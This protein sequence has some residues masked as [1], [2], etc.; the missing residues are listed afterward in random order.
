MLAAAG[1][2]AKVR[3][4]GQALAVTDKAEALATQ[5]DAAC[6]TI[7][8]RTA[9]ID[10]RKRVLFVLSTDGGK[11]QASGTDTAAMELLNWRAPSTPSMPIPTTR[12]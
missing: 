2:L 7:K 12:P 8:A 1:I 3:A 11:I 9:Y 10:E 6:S 4:V 5:L